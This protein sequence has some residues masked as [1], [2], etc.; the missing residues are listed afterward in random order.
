MSDHRSRERQSRSVE[1]RSRLPVCRFVFIVEEANGRML[2]WF[3]SKFRLFGKVESLSSQEKLSHVQRC[4]PDRRLVFA[5]MWRVACGSQSS[6]HYRQQHARKCLKREQEPPGAEMSKL[7]IG[8]GC[9]EGKR[10]SPLTTVSA[11]RKQTR[12]AVNAWDTSG[13][14][15]KRHERGQRDAHRREVAT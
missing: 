13:R 3:L 5:V 2:P 4:E 10:A 8:I 7:A 11:V 1:L 14:S 9:S 12:Q 6:Q 15:R